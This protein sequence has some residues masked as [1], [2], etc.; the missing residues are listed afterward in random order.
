M[1]IA[2]RWNYEKATTILDE[3]LNHGDPSDPKERKRLKIVQAATELFIKYGYRKTSISK[4]AKTAGVAK[5]TI[6]IYFETKADLLIHAIGE[7]KKRYF[8]RLKPVF[9]PELPPRER[10]R[11][12]LKTA[13]VVGTEMPLVSKLMGGDREILSAMADMDA[14][15]NQEWEMMRFDFLGEMLDEAAAPH[16]WTSMELRDRSA[17]MLGFVYFSGLIAD[18]RIRSGLSVDRFAEILADMIVDGI[19]VSKAGNDQL[20]HRGGRK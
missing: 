10:L 12:W 11:L 16:T 3:F 17:V 5:G 9:D 6:Y 4:I 13:L 7:E 1:V 8:L 14:N 15:Q 2:M 18:D 20:D 19:G